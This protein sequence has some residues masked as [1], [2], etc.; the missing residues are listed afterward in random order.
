METKQKTHL[1]TSEYQ[2]VCVVCVCIHVYVYMC[3]YMCAYCIC[4][5]VCEYMCA[6]VCV[7][8]CGWLEA[9]CLKGFKLCQHVVRNS[10]LNPILVTCH[11]Q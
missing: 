1:P 7:S 6:C 8:V 5:P 3:V 4:V 9:F 11:L 10:H 2:C